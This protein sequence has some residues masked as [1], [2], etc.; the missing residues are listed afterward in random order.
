M[1][2]LPRYFIVGA[3]P[4]KVIRNQDGLTGTYAYNWQTGDFD[5]NWEYYEQTFSGKGEVER[6]SE[7]E[8]N[9][10]VERLRNEPRKKQT[11]ASEEN[12]GG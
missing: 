5:L 6:V 10:H 11:N 9:K 4:V 7:E 2:D 12:I 8:F 1:D 3:R